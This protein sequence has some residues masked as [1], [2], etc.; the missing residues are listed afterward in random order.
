[1]A[2]PL[3]SVVLTAIPTLAVFIGLLWFR[4]RKKKP[5]EID[6]HPPQVLLTQSSEEGRK[7]T[8]LVPAGG[9]LEAI[10][11]ES[12]Q[13]KDVMNEIA[14][15][16]TVKLC[17]EIV[18]SCSDTKGDMA[19]VEEEIVSQSVAPVQSCVIASHVTEKTSQ[20]VD[21]CKS[22]T[23]GY[24]EKCSKSVDHSETVVN[25]SERAKVCVHNQ[26][27]S[28]SSN[29]VKPVLQDIGNIQNTDSSESVSKTCIQDQSAST[30]SCNYEEETE[31]HTASSESNDEASDLASEL[32]HDSHKDTTRKE[33]RVRKWTDEDQWDLEESPV[34]SPI[35]HGAHST[36][37]SE[38][39]NDSGI[40]APSQLNSKTTVLFEFNFP[41]ELCGL[42][43]GSKGKN[44]KKLMDQTATNIIVKDKMYD[45]S[46][47][48]ITITGTK[49]SVDKT[50]DLLRKKFPPKKYPMVNFGPAPRENVKLI[51]EMMQLS[52]PEGVFI[53]V[54]VSSVVA[55]NHVFVQQPTHPSFPMLEKQNMFMNLCYSQDGIIPQL[56]RP[57]ESG[58]ICAAP[59]LNGWYRAQIVQSYGETD[60]ADLRFVDYGGYCR[61]PAS[62]LRQIRS[63]FT[64]LPFQA[65]ECYLANVIPPSELGCFPPEANAVLE[66]A[67]HGQMAQ[68]E[69]VGHEEDGVP[70]INLYVLRANKLSLV[71]RELVEQQVASWLEN[72]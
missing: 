47:Q 1:M 16:E 61:E 51:P 5:P 11:E 20:S 46:H 6:T 27:S 9:D 64:T 70:F 57:V 30:T 13:N 40:V 49:A 65:V 8:E 68:V 41:S 12:L 3:R 37:G 63:D 50:L 2:F 54:I 24:Q 44:I 15:S 32:Q 35:D 43:I 53:D 48:L 7:V 66:Q 31:D 26:D 39:S 36:N 67:V 14:Q 42:L 72:Y 10:A 29:T 38:A 59:M 34:A 4:R 18:Q 69:V 28:V 58:V 62:A 21:S 25:Q 17:E 45:P 60:E 19:P 55:P 22:V 33:G 23:A 52:L 56:P 71:N